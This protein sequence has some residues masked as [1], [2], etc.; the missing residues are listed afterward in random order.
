MLNF[1]AACLG[2]QKP[3]CAQIC[4]LAFLWSFSGTVFQSFESIYRADH[5]EMSCLSGIQ[6]HLPIRVLFSLVHLAVATTIVTVSSPSAEA[7]LMVILQKLLVITPNRNYP[8]RSNISQAL[9]SSFSWPSDCVNGFLNHTFN[10]KVI[11]I[12][13]PWRQP[14]AGMF[15]LIFA[16]FGV[17]C[18]HLGCSIYSD[19]LFRLRISCCILNTL[20]S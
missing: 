15:I 17:S 4:T 14:I 8:Y 20:S 1:Q 3:W 5:I 19:S 18:N 11:H 2:S 9:A 16:K 13:A 10:L 6:Q 12:T 7:V